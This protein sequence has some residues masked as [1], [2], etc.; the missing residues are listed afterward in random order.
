MRAAS[1][2]NRHVFA[3]IRDLGPRSLDRHSYRGNTE[4]NG[5][6]EAAEDYTTLLH[7]VEDA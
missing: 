2:T 3:I 1:L 7:I 5:A 4:S 6:T